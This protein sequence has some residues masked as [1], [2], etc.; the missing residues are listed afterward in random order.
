MKSED[1]IPQCKGKLVFS[2]AE[3]ADRVKLYLEKCPQLLYRGDVVCHSGHGLSRPDGY[4]T[5]EN[6]AFGEV[7]TDVLCN[8]KFVIP[9]DKDCTYN[10]GNRE[11]A[12]ADRKEKYRDFAAQKEYCGNSET[13]LMHVLAMRGSAGKYDVKDYQVPTTN[14][15][16]DKIDIVL[17]RGNNIYIT[18]AK[19]FESHE[20]LARCVLEIETYYQKLNER[21]YE[22]Y[23][24]TFGT[25]KRTNTLKKAVLFD[26]SSFAHKQL[27]FC[28]WAKRLIE[29]FDIQ[30]LTLSETES[31]YSIEAYNRYHRETY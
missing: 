21:F 11:K 12:T 26:E 5:R 8:E 13:K 16:C 23:D 20:S 25:L 22:K 15:N 31:G 28:D 29:K 10:S 2:S 30:I 7:I 6:I 24:C 19:R 18:E 1:I 9:V 4:V 3:L 17:K 27:R 14:G